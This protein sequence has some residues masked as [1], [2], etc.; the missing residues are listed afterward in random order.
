[1]GLRATLTKIRKP[2]VSES[3]SKNV[4]SPK[5]VAAKK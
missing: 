2:K 4:L 1:M 3:P 5:K